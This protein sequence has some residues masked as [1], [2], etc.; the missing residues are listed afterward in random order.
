MTH[1]SRFVVILLS[2]VA[3]LACIACSSKPVE[4]S[5]PTAAPSSSGNASP[6]AGTEANQINVCSFFSPADAQSIMGVPMKLSAKTNRQ[7]NCIYEEVT[8]RP[9]TIGAGT[10]ALTLNQ[11]KSVED[12]NRDWA[13]LKEVRHLQAGQKNVQ[14]LSGIGDEAYFTGNSQKDK[15]GVAA[16]VLRK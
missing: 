15:V 13:N 3:I 16:V 4:N 1:P 6:T 14:V 8:A 2:S 12:E 11:A 5:A 9:N 7:R 10:I